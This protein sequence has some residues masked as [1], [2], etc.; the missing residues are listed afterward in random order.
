MVICVIEG[1]ARDPGLLKKKRQ[2]FRF[3]PTTT[4]HLHT[5]LPS[6]HTNPL[7]PCLPKSPSSSSSPRVTSSLLAARPDSTFP[8]L[9]VLALSSCAL[10]QRSM[11]TYCYPCLSWTTGPP[12]RSHQAL[13]LSCS[14]IVGS[15]RSP[16]PFRPCLD[17]TSSTR[18]S[19]SPSP[20]L[21][22]VLLLWTRCVA[23]SPK[24]LANCSGPFRL[25]AH[26]EPDCSSCH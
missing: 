12:V 19:S 9:F 18:T 7:Q 23:L 21:T 4:F 24:D 15:S 20:P 14:A 1:D 17:T 10:S 13:D 26:A 8:R 2:V 3:P 5:S 22:E 16:A 25:P 6:T 11:L